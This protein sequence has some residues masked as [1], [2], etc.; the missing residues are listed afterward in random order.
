MEAHFVTDKDGNVT[1]VNVSSPGLQS[2]RNYRANNSGSS[3]KSGGGSSKQEK[4]WENPYDQ[5]YNL[6]ERNEEAI[7]R[8][9]ILEK[10][11]NAILRDREGSS[12]HLLKNNLKELANLQ[13]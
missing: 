5:L 7:R 6:T 4:P 2:I 11:Y 13:E 8:R 9:N 10:Q 1:R 12:D 3:K